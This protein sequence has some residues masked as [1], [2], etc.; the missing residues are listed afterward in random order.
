M[1]QKT[2]ILIEWIK[3]HLELIRTQK[4]EIIN[5]NV[6]NAIGLLNLLPDLESKLC[7][8]GY[9]QDVNGVPCCN[10]DKIKQGNT[11]GVLYWSKHDFRFYRKT[12]DTLYLLN[13]NFRKVE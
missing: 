7:H 2:K 6:D 9:I 10:G 12:N 11:T 1:K 4:N 3:L 5:N 8:G 13:T